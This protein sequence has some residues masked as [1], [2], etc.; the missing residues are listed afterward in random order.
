MILYNFYYKKYSGQRY[1]SK[2]HIVLTKSVLTSRNSNTIIVRV[3][4]KHNH[5]NKEVFHNTITTVF[6]G[7][8]DNC[9]HIP[10]TLSSAIKMP[11]TLRG[12]SD[13][14]M[15]ENTMLYNWIWETETLNFN[16]EWEL[17]LSFS[18][19]SMFMTTMT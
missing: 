11:N 1:K 18:T 17:K 2:F 3:E 19:E 8:Y 15:N 6:V 10:N 14:C 7:G 4:Y 13:E 9:L 5:R 16:I 12:F